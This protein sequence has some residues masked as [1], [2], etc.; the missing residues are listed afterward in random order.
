MMGRIFTQQHQVVKHFKKYLDRMNGNYEGG[1]EVVGKVEISYPRVPKNTLLGVQELLDY[2]LERR[3]KIYD[4]EVEAK[5]TN[6]Q[7]RTTHSSQLCFGKDLIDDSD[8]TAPQPPRPKAATSQYNRSALSTRTCRSKQPARSLR[9]AIYCRHNP[10][11]NPEFL[12][13]HLRHE[14]H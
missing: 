11:S 7:V 1:E 10:L 8:P 12:H 4:L 5:R 6:D 3:K 14:Q 2:I 9:H 13:Q